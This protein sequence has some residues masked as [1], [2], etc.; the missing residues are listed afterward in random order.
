M[1]ATIRETGQIVADRLTVADSILSRLKGLLGRDGLQEGEGLW[2]KPCRGVHTFGMRFTIDVVFLDRSHRVVAIAAE[3]PPNR[4][5]RIYGKAE[6][7]LELPA[8]SAAFFSM[9]VG[10]EV[11]F[12]G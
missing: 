1:R 2:L 4:L 9:Q 5:T 8:G 7:V 6:S 12:A 3:L 11:S 10:H